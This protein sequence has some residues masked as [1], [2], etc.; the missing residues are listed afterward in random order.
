MNT[1]LDTHDHILLVGFMGSGKS[2]VS[3]RLSR[4]TGLSLIDVDYRIEAIQH[5]KITQIF[6]EEDEEGF[7]AI[8]T[9]TL[10]S[11][12]REARSIIS[13]GGG[14][15]CNPVNR[16]ILKDLGTVIYLKVSLEEAVGRIS[17]PST[18][19][20]LSGPRPVE[21]IYAER[22]A[23]YDEVADITLETDGMTPGKVAML[24]KNKLEE[25]GLL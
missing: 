5:R 3:R 14:I 17:N 16:P 4:I 10:R 2:T 24:C 6:A 11:L 13:C 18:R 15:V 20:M 7:R 12:T 8:E 22:L 19:P 25:R 23:Y 9:N 21:E 1:V